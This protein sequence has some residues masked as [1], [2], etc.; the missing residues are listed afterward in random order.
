MFF[1]SLSKKRFYLE[2]ESVLINTFQGRVVGTS[3]VATYIST[4]LGTMRVPPAAG[5]RLGSRRFHIKT[6]TG[7]T[8][9]PF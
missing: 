7:E 9:N 5:D 1:D 8:D 3:A 6:A 2:N 4:P